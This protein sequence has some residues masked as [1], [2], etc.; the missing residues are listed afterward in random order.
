M[1]FSE[2]GF[3][4]LD[5]TRLEIWQITLNLILKCVSVWLINGKF[6]VTWRQVQAVVQPKATL[7]GKCHIQ[8]SI[9]D[10]ESMVQATKELESVVEPMV[11]DSDEEDE[12]TEEKQE[13]EDSTL[14]QI[15]QS[16]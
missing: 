13:E 5:I 7:K 10:K 6:G 9:S 8:L 15:P 14:P 12:D 4:G 3:Q 2:L 1:E 16:K 11:A